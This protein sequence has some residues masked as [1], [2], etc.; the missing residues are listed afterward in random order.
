MKTILEIGDKVRV[1]QSFDSDAYADEVRKLAGQYVTI[2][3]K[4][5]DWGYYIK[6][7]EGLYCDGEWEIED[8]DL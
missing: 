8:F 7:T 1:K 3:D 5:G 4:C 2:R 6:E